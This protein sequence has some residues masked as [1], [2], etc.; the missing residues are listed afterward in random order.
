MQ[1]IKFDNRTTQILKNFSTI[2]P[3]LLF[4]QGSA[5]STI[6]PSKTILAKAK[7]TQSM[8]SQFAIYDLSRFLSVLSLFNDPELRIEDKF[9]TIASGD[10]KLN[11][12]FA[13]ASTIITPP[14][15]EITITNP[16]V[17]FKLTTETFNDVTKASSVLR[18]PEIAIVGEDGDISVQAIDSK[19]PS[20]DIYSIK[21]GA[22]EKKFKMIFKAENLKILSGDY[23]V[24]LTKGISHFKG[25][26]VEYF[27]AIEANSTYDS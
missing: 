20:G 24:A 15:K 2:N 7:I 27:I 21:V 4:K 9:I 16:Q 17:E 12:T 3:S 14:D 11:Y 13:D 26:D 23:E 5:I 10:K 19:N 22:T 6:S 1:N 8:D 18:L 25:V